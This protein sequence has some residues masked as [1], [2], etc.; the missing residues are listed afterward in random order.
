[1]TIFLIIVSILWGMLIFLHT[2]EEFSLIS[3]IIFGLLSTVFWPLLL[4]AAVIVQ[5]VNHCKKSSPDFVEDEGELN[6]QEILEEQIRKN[7]I[8]KKNEQ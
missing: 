6:P 3:S 4:L 2:R 7:L 5:I 1:M 8:E